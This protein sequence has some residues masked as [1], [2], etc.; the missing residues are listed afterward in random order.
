M[1]SLETLIRLGG[2]LH[3]SLLVAGGLL[4]FVLNWQSDLKKLDRLSQQVVWTHGVFIVLVVVGFGAA[5][6][7]LPDALLAGTP[8]ARSLCGFIALFWLA[9][10]F[11]QLFYLDAESHLTNWF[12]R[13]G[14]RGLTGVFMYLAIVYAFAAVAPFAE[15]GR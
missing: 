3:V 9:R 4:P 7:F 8:L 5:S 2:V 1:C 11:I 10:L 6:L 15:F 12:F 14:Y 13:L